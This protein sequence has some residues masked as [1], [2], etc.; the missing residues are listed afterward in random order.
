MIKT[1]R[2]L[3]HKT[4]IFAYKRF[5]TP[6]MRFLIK[7]MGGNVGAA[8]EVFAET[9]LAAWRSWHTFEHKSSFFTWVC[10]I[11]LNK[12]ADYYRKQIDHESRIIAPTLEEIANI[13]SQEISLEEQL[14]LKQLRESIKECLRLLPESKRKLLY[15]RYWK[16][17]TIKKIAL[18]TGCSERAVEGK[19]YRA[20]LEFKEILRTKY[21]ELA[22]IE[23]MKRD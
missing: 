21:P 20:K 17:M 4:F 8:E 3:R 6:L 14:A 1:T 22:T 5:A 15:L 12:M 9:M 11:G 13:G 16:D 2:S 7:K 10:R 18:S 19:I 23:I